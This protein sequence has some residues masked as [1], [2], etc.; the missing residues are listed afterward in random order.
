[1]AG[2]LIGSLVAGRMLLGANS[3]A[4]QI[5]VVPAELTSYRD[6]VKKVLPAV[7][8]IQG[9]ALQTKAKKKVSRRRLPD[10]LQI[11]D[12]LRKFFEDMPDEEERPQLGFG[13]G[14]LVDAKGVVL[15]N[16]HVVNGA[17]EVE[18][19]LMDGRKFLTK[20]IHGDRKTDLAIVR[21]DAK[22]AGPL[23]YLELGD[24]DAMEIGDHVLAVGAP[25]GLTGT[26]TSGI[27]SAKGRHGFG[28]NLYED[29]LQTDAAINPGNSGGPLVNIQGQ[30]VG[31][32]SMIKS[33]TGG[34]QG[35]GL[36]VAS[37]LAKSIMKQLETS[38]VVHRGYLGVQIRDLSPAVAARLGVKGKHGVVVGDVQEGSPAAHGGLKAGDIITGING[39]SVQDGRELQTVVAGLTLNK[40]AD[41]D[42]IRDGKPLVLKV[43][44]KE[45]PNNFGLASETQPERSGG[46]K[47]AITLDKIGLE[48]TD[49]TP[50]SAKALGYKETAAGALVTKVDAESAADEAGLARGMLIE[51]V[52]RQR[53][54]SAKA[55][56]DLVQRAP[57]A[58]GVVLQVRSPG[59]GVNYL[60]LKAVAV[61]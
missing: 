18:V 37:N 33:R 41:V 42:I 45:Q 16:F 49:L 43:T 25:F 44:I 2:A 17:D 61:K 52:N 11:P 26:V 4:D 30:V 5:K 9:K 14:F 31:I 51:K 54:K 35:I 12:D 36:A 15:T 22:D 1:M 58:R 34:F 38:G 8:S 29:F 6:V 13:S 3:G 23:P 47:E 24:S 28:M 39:K 53:V 48:V 21:L 20:D 19:T 57:L 7:V 32:N 10:D 60:L 50:E 40:A 46:E 56:R 59:S 55:F 27:V